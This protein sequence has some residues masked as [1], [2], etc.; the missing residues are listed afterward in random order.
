MI[1]QEVMGVQGAAKFLGVAPNTIYNLVKHREI[2]VSTVGKQY[3]FTR[4]ELLSWLSDKCLYHRNYLKEYLD[5]IFQEAWAYGKK[6]GEKPWSDKK[7]I[8]F[9]ESV[10][11]ERK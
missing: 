3:K 11:K 2:P 8:E 7:V 1:M 10:R 5:K 4:L 9:V 6:R